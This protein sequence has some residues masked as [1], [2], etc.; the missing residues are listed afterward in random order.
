[1]ELAAMNHGVYIEVR[2]SDKRAVIAILD[3]ILSRPPIDGFEI[4]ENVQNK[5]REK[6][7]VLLPDDVL[8]AGFLSQKVD[9]DGTYAA[10]KSL[11]GTAGPKKAQDAAAD[12]SGG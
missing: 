7:D 9:I 10:L 4:A 5:M 6:W 3:E 2:K 1:M 11:L 8:N 12:S